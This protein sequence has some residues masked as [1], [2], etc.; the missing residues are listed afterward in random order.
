MGIKKTRA[1]FEA[2]IYELNVKGYL[3]IFLSQANLD[4]LLKRVDDAAAST[5]LGAI[6]NV[7]QASSMV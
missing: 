6:T 4:D 3:A 2:S 5:I 1:G 7:A